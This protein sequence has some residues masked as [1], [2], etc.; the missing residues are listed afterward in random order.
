MT[1]VAFAEDWTFTG[2]VR[3]KAEWKREGKARVTIFVRL[4][5]DKILLNEFRLILDPTDGTIVSSVWMGKPMPTLKAPPKLPELLKSAINR[6]CR[7]VF[8][9]DKWDF[10]AKNKGQI[11]LVK[12]EWIKGETQSGRRG[13]LTPAPHTTGHT[14][15]PSAMLKWLRRVGRR[16]DGRR[17]VARRFQYATCYPDFFFG[18]TG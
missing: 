18:P 11:Q 6:P 17:V 3:D 8:R 5:T 4:N 16:P 7:I 1:S 15:L 10:N 12:F 13:V 9:S 2:V 14:D